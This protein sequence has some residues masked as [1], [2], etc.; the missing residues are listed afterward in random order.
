[1]KAEA[2][3]EVPCKKPAA[4][5]VKA[6]DV[7]AEATA[8]P[9]EAA[10]QPAEA[11]APPPPPPPAGVPGPRQMAAATALILAMGLPP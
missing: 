10:A 6:K 9:A 4:K 1:M 7:K 3:V 2:D 5:A 8:P 11:A